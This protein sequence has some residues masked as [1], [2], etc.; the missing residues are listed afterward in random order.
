MKKNRSI[1]GENMDKSGI[2]YGTR[3]IHS[4]AT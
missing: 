2:F 3:C 4:G 1:F